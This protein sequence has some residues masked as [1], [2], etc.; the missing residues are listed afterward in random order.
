MVH[1]STMHGLQCWYK[2]EFEKLGWMV[3]AKSE[4]YDDKIEHYK[5]GLEHL[6]KS[7]EAKMASVMDV[8]KKNDLKIMWDH[9]KVLLAHVQNDF[10]A[11]ATMGGKMKK[12]GS[13]K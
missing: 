3:L 10:P 6:A 7:I 11:A 13:K 8:D 5:K 1:E 9:T 4:G 12:R 2:A